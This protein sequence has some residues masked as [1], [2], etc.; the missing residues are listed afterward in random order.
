LDGKYGFKQLK[1]R[2]FVNLIVELQKTKEQT[3]EYFDLS[4]VKLNHA[5]E[6]GKWTARQLLNHLADAETVLY[7]RLRRIISEEKPVIW[8][9]NQDAWCKELEYEQFPLSINKNVYSSVRVSIIYLAENYYEKF[10]SKEFIH[11]E[12]GLRTLKDEFNK[13]ANHNKHHLNQIAKAIA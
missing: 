4:E 6:K 10:G 12:T 9:F 1:N 8:A 7:D 2:L 13:I 11:S 5:Y 3:L